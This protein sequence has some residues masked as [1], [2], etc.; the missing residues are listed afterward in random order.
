MQ[1]R[2]IDPV[3]PPADTQALSP[4]KRAAVRALPHAGTPAVA[5]FDTLGRAFL[6]VADNG[7]D[8]NGNEQKYLT[9]VEFDIEG[10]QLAVVDAR[11]RVVMLYDHDLLGNRIHQNSMDAG[12]RWMLNDVTGKPVRVW[13]TPPKDGHPGHTFRTEYDELRRPV[14]SFVKGSVEN[15]PGREILY[16][17]MAYGEKHPRAEALNLHARV[18]LQLDGA[19]MVRNGNAIVPADGLEEAYDFKGNL[20]RS[21]R[22]LAKD[23]KDTPDWK[24]LEPLFQPATLDLAAIENGLTPLLEP[25]FFE[26]SARFDALNRPTQVVAP[27]S[28]LPDKKRNVIRPGYNEANLLERVDVWLERY[29]EPDGLLDPATA[30]ARVGVSNIDYNAK[31]QRQRIEYKNGANTNYT[32]EKETFRLA[33][34]ETS[35]GA[36]RL[37]DLQYNYDP[38]GNITSI[39]DDAQQTI[40][41]GNQMVEP[42][43]DYI[44]D[45]IYRLIKAT[46]REHLGQTANPPMP[47]DE[48]NFFHIRRNPND[49]NVMGRYVEEYSYDEVGNILF[50]HHRGADPQHPGWKRCYQYAENSNRLLSNSNPETA[51]NPDD[52]CS[53]HYAA[54]PVLSEKYGY[55]THGNMT[56]MSHL[57]AM[58]WDFRDQLRNVNLGGGGNAFYAYD[59]SGQRV[60]KVW[61]KN[62]RVEERIYLGGFEVFRSRNGIGGAAPLERETL[63]IMDDKQ[64]VA[65][66]ETRTEGVDPAPRQLIRYQ[67]G[68]HLGSSALELDH[69]AAVISYEEYFPYGNASYQAVRSQTE[70]PKRYHYTGKERDE[71]SGLHY[72]GAR[73]Y[74][75]WLGRWTATDPSDVAD[76]LN[77]YLYAG[78]NPVTKFDPNGFWETDMH[79]LGVYWAG[80][81]QGANHVQAMIAAIGSQSLDDSQ[82]TSAPGLKVFGGHESTVG[83]AISKSGTKA[84]IQ[85]A[86]NSHSLGLTK[87]ESQKVA[88][89]GIKEQNVLLFGLG[90]HT[91]GDY[92]PH[93]NLSGEATGGH[94]F[95]YNEDFSKS[96]H[97]LHHADYTFKNPLKAL[98]TFERFRELWS[99]YLS[100]GSQYKKLELGDKHLASVAKFIFTRND[101]QA[102]KEAAFTEGL[103]ALGVD[104][105]DIS[106]ALE[107]YRDPN[108]RLDAMKRMK[109]TIK[110]GDA[111]ALANGIW[112]SQKSNSEFL[113]SGGFTRTPVNISRDLNSVA[114][115]TTKEFESRRNKNLTEA[116]ARYKL[117][118][119]DVPFPKESVYSPR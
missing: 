18:F 4:E 31:G 106:Q 35:R 111:I 10:N 91:V 38:V 19:G 42:H 45:A 102:G 69:E 6:T 115:I 76:G 53:P 77:V 17:R 73:Y 47:Y 81:M 86:N 3:N 36:E 26:S 80:R 41:F 22:R 37:Q 105:S 16:E 33:R 88:L 54:A 29:G 55:D 70:M 57:S 13:D 44:Y 94:Q 89:R 9:R 103:K 21:S 15:D 8:A 11:E 23:Y 96:H 87:L 48:F 98:A 109:E 82:K 56:S 108:K 25:E 24:S 68:N 43:N 90:L 51:H 72:H 97:L 7:E 117:T 1:Q 46:G 12:E 79:F 50:V 40:I 32:Y 58:G 101:D 92:L 63:H 118:P 114:R 28:N 60:R 99:K 116:L 67:L 20:L 39:R 83:N 59:A 110:G 74:A 30:E 61:E 34:L 104:D 65:L 49:P 75:C 100:D 119:L 27:H 5:Y 85:L 112:L 64:R 93:A 66:V 84:Q 78:N 107:F 113:N 62:G 14:R 71:E 2:A 52:A 95:G